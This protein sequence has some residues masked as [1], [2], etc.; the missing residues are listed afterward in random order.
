M[1]NF[2]IP[3]ILP[4]DWFKQ[5]NNQWFVK[6][7]LGNSA[8]TNELKQISNLDKSDLIHF[9]LIADEFIPISIY[10]EHQNGVAVMK[11]FYSRYGIN[12]TDFYPIFLDGINYPCTSDDVKKL[13]N[14]LQRLKDNEYDLSQTFVYIGYL[15]NDL[16]IEKITVDDFLN[17]NFKTEI[18]KKPLTKVGE[19]FIRAF[20]DFRDCFNIRY[21]G[22]YSSSLLRKKIKNLYT[23]LIHYNLTNAKEYHNI[24]EVVTLYEDDNIEEQQLMEQLFGFNGFRNNIHNRIRERLEDE[25]FIKL[26]GNPEMLNNIMECM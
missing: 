20:E 14:V 15:T 17:G 18:I 7:H 21:H 13:K 23:L 25:D 5:K 12:Y 22:K 19:N 16:S 2:V 4:P 24:L 3:H 1:N 11:E 8:D 26:I 9:S 10:D 6:T